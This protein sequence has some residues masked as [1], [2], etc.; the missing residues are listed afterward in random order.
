[1]LF[2]A[3]GVSGMTISPQIWFALYTDATAFSLW[4]YINNRRYNVSPYEPPGSRGLKGMLMSVLAAPLY[5]VQL[6]STLGRRPAK[7]VVTPKGSSS[8][9]DGLRT[10]RNPIGWAVLLIGAIVVSFVRGY[11]SP[12]A[13]LWPGAG[14]VICLLALLL[15]R[16]EP[17]LNRGEAT[18][19]CVPRQAGTPEH[20]GDITMEIPRE[21]LEKH[22]AERR[23]RRQHEDVGA[24]LIM[25]RVDAPVPPENSERRRTVRDDYT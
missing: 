19:A 23:A 2:L 10:F 18:E 16:L 12:A 20:A 15:W 21:M 25:P 8:S 3:L 9:S 24:T 5:A 1:V 13:L 4:L 22:L 6:M 11:A 14:I 17:V 7:F